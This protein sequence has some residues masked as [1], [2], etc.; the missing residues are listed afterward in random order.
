[1]SEISETHKECPICK[2]WIAKGLAED[3]F[4]EHRDIEESLRSIIK[5]LDALA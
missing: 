3:H 2:R 1:M 5:A 4:G